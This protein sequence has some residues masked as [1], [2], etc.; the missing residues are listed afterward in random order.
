MAEHKLE[1]N[2]GGDDR[3]TD[4][5]V[6]TEKSEGGYGEVVWRDGALKV[7]VRRALS[8]CFS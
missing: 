6:D 7:A 5:M 4:V 1:W 2:G 8:H 3:E